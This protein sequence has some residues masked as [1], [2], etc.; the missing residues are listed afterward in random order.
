MSK[1]HDRATV[2]TKEQGIDVL[3]DEWNYVANCF[4]QLRRERAGLASVPI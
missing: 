2:A 3:I 1:R 4:T